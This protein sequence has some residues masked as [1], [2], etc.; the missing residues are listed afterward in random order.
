MPQTDLAVL[1]G[2][3]AGTV[4][5]IKECVHCGRPDRNDF[6]G[7]RVREQGFG[8]KWCKIPG[9]LK[10]FSNTYRSD[11]F[12]PRMIKAGHFNRYEAFV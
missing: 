9:D 4:L 1:S 10:G 11:P 5:D 12:I 2:I 7:R 6:I 3:Q 8:C